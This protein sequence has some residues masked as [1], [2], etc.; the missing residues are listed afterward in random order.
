MK[1]GIMLIVLG[2]AFLCSAQQNPLPFTWLGSTWGLS[3]EDTTLSPQIQEVVRKDV[4]HLFAQIHTNNA[5]IELG[6]I[7]YHPSGNIFFPDKLY[8]SAYKTV[9]ATNTFTIEPEVSSNYLEKITLTNAHPTMIA[10]LSNFLAQVSACSSGN[11]TDTDFTNLLWSLEKDAQMTV[12][13]WG[14]RSIQGHK[15]G[16]L[17][18]TYGFPSLLDLSVIDQSDRTFIICALRYALPKDNP[19]QPRFG[20]IL[21]YVNNQWYFAD[22]QF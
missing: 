21:I 19:T 5:V 17:D 15:E 16:S 8:L 1:K 10:G 14:E 18:V 13:D 12:Q 22:W 2:M 3:F 4:E 9:N 11:T 6:N 20:D 7:Q